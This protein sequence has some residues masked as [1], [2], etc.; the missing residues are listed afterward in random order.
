M[1][2]WCK[3]ILY[4]TPVRTMLYVL[5]KTPCFWK[6]ELPY[7]RVEVSLN[8]PCKGYCMSVMLSRWSWTGWWVSF[9]QSWVLVLLP[10]L[11]CRPSQPETKQSNKKPSHIRFMRKTIHLI[12]KRHQIEILEVKKET[13]KKV[14]YQ[15]DEII[16][17]LCN[18]VMYGYFIHN[19]I[20]FF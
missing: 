12:C 14:T 7:V 10:P 2:L 6:E 11:L 8:W 18:S 17:L 13:Q 4:I 19:Q 5:Q 15:F 3:D 1:L 16:E 9:L 20:I